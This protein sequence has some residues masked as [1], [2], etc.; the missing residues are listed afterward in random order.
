MNQKKWL[1]VSLVALAL[2][3]LVLAIAWALDNRPDRYEDRETHPQETYIAVGDAQLSYTG[4]LDT[5]AYPAGAPAGDWLAGCSAPDRDE[6]ID[7]YILRHTDE[8]EG[9]ST[10]TYLIY[11]PH[12]E[13]RLVATPTLEEGTDEYRLNLTLREAAAGDPATEGYL[14]ARISV[15]LPAAKAPR[16]RL[17]SGGD[18]LGTLV[19]ESREAIE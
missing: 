4:G 7:A 10:F 18:V 14:L 13:G 5:A 15:T 16:L 8:R 11:Y 12:G 17:L 6:F 9:E 3:L 19:S 2:I 1:A